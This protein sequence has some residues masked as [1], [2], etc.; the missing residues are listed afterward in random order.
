MTIN[1]IRREVCK[2]VSKLIKNGYSRKWAF[3]WAW[4]RVKKELNQIKATD[5]K[6]GD[7]VCIEFGD[8]NNFAT[9]VIKSIRQSDKAYLK[10][11]LMVVGETYGG[12]D[13]EFGVE[14]SDRLDKAA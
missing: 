12:A 4:E 7:K 2:R 9:V 3:Q 6:V 13:I 14:L 8:N 1:K 10:N 5:L 11:Y